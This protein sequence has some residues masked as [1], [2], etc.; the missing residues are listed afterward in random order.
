MPEA[1]PAYGLTA[2]I[3][4]WLIAAILVAQFALGWLMPAVRRGAEPGFS[5]HTHISIGIVVLALILVR[6]LWRLTHRVPPEPQLPR[7]QRLGST[8]VHWLLYLLVVVATL[9]GW[10]HASAHGWAL[11]F[12]GLFPLPALA[13]HGSAGGRAIGDIHEGVVLLLLGVIAIHLLAALVHAFVYRDQVM[14]R[15]LF[16]KE[17]KTSA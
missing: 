1:P 13:G 14:Q 12:F 3:L 4:H 17:R 16:G 8:V 11:T 6:L 7:W 2:K 9:S 10:F 5:M 15:M